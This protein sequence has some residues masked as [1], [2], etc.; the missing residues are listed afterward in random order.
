MAAVTALP[1]TGFHDDPERSQTMRASYYHDPAVFAR[2]TKAV[3]HAT[4]QY[5]GHVSMLP[6]PGSYMVRDILDQSVLV[7]RAASGEIRA[8]FNVCQHRA[9]RLLEGEGRIGPTV[10]CPYHNWAYGQDGALR[11]ARGSEK[12]T[13]FDPAQYRLEPV[14]LGEMLGFLFVNLD[15]RAPDF[16][17]VAGALKAEIASFSPNA[18]ALKC[19]DRSEYR[20]AANWKNS[21]ENYDECFHCPNQHRTLIEEALDWDS[22]RIHTH[23]HHHTHLSTEKNVG[24]A[25]RTEG[26]AKPESF[27]SWLLWPNWVIEAYPGGNLTVFHHD[28]LE[29]ELTVQRCEWYFPHDE[30]SAKEREVIDFVHAVRLEDIPLCE[31]VQRGLHSLGYR[32]GRFVVD[33]GR[34]EISEHA[35]HDFQ[36]KWLIAMGERSGAARTR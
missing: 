29:P 33:P 18:A 13:G 30:P 24:Y 36:R 11:S 23:D 26:A 19:A 32:Q 16:E 20:L 34:T 22:Y 4:W 25:T 28:P 8:F 35:V 31:S 10:T 14:R 15:G 6:A 2:E 3:F 17:T 21:V 12:M 7:L 1:V 9:H 27:A 5:V